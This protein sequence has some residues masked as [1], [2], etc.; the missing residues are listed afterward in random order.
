MLACCLPCEWVPHA[1]G[2]E[3]AGRAQVNGVVQFLV[4]PGGEWVVDLK[5]GNGS[6]KAGRAAKAD[7]TLT[8]SDDDFVMLAEGK[9]NPQQAFMRGKLKVACPATLTRLPSCPTHLTSAPCLHPVTFPP[10]QGQHG[11]RYE[12][13]GRHQ[14]RRDEE[15][16]VDAGLGAA[17]DFDFFI[18]SS[19]GFS[20]QHASASGC[21]LVQSAWSCIVAC[22][23]C[24]VA[25]PRPSW[26]VECAHATSLSPTNGGAR[27][28][29]TVTTASPPMLQMWMM[30][31]SGT[32]QRCVGN[33]ASLS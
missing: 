31:V 8:V 23:H 19:H 9:L 14:G 20:H 21:V 29:R 4:T 15:Q 32:L 33:S 18:K 5:N 10:A 6:V 27:F 12:A 25:P 11:P 22:C 16:A 17:A 28:A 2:T 3:R 7:L 26:S 30:A 24:Q 13:W 1:H